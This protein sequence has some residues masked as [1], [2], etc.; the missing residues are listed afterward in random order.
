MAVQRKTKH[1]AVSVLQSTPRLIVDC[2]VRP[3]EPQLEKT[4]LLIFA[5]NEDSDQPAHPRVFVVRLKKLHPW[6]FKLHT[7]GRF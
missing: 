6:L 5:P 3:Y 7:Q 1:A 2:D 4:Y